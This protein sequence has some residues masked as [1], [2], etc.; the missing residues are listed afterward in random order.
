MNEFVLLSGK[1]SGNNTLRLTR[2]HDVGSTVGE[3][4]L[5]VVVPPKEHTTIGVG[6]VKMVEVVAVAVQA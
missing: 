3:I 6:V 5:S 1:F 2:G 4:G